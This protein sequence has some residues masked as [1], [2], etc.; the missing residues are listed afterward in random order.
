MAKAFVGHSFTDDDKKL[1][2]SVT[3]FLEAF[4][5][6]NP[7]FV[8]VHAE[9]AR[10]EDIVDK[11]LPMLRS[12]DIFIGI[13]S[14]K[15]R[16]ATSSSFRS[17]LWNKKLQVIEESSLQWKTSD[18]IIQEIA[19]AR[20]R[21]MRLILLLE[22][23]VRAPGGLHGNVEYIQ[24]QRDNMSN[25]YLRLTQ[26]LGAI[27][28]QAPPPQISDVAAPEHS[29]TGEA[30]KSTDESPLSAPKATWEAI[31]YE[32]ALFHAILF[33]DDE[34]LQTV[35]EA[36]SASELSKRENG[37]SRWEARKEY[38]LLIL[39][40]GGSFVN[41]EKMV[42]QH[43]T[44]HAMV[45]M[46]ARAVSH[47]NDDRGAIK[48]HEEAAIAATKA[49]SVGAAARS[50]ATAVELCCK[51]KDEV[52]A[53][54]IMSLLAALPATDTDVRD[55]R[56]RAT[57]LM[58]KFKGHPLLRI[59]ALEYQ[60]A[61]APSDAD[62]RF[63]LAYAYSEAD[64]VPATLLHY[65]AIPDAR[66]NDTAWNNLGVARQSLKLSVLAIEAFN[67]AEQKGNTLSM[68]NL[69]L[70][71]LKAG[72]YSEAEA[73]CKK[74]L[75]GP[76]PHDNLPSTFAQIKGA[77]IDEKKQ[78]ESAIEEAE[79]RSRLMKEL[80]R[81]MLDPLPDLVSTQ[82]MGPEC[83]LTLMRIGDQI[84]LR[85]QYEQQPNALFRAL[86]GLASTDT[87]DLIVKG[88]LY[89][90]AAVGTI[91]RKKKGETTTSTALALGLHGPSDALILFADDA[92]SIGVVENPGKNEKKFKIDVVSNA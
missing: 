58:A 49:G 87:Y 37:F 31:D 80:G 68:S 22:V 27:L 63:A 48:L 43:R 79:P 5:G 32:M 59:A 89:G 4:K 55:A 34:Y 9:G 3:E 25:A 1:V 38:S 19:I 33:E 6:S 44:D 18:W 13:C 14:K 50:L 62:K 70:A 23:G 53:R 17:A 36:F 72:F 76:D 41:L 21:E 67:T 24:F 65:L 29:Q 84:E 12:C 88:T 75:E 73:M 54:R 60:V 47:F 91:E 51:V 85:G 16:V 78:E 11:V 10:P 26:M 56:L 92:R 28:V 77:R 8:W 35:N 83:P 7:A 20:E 42:N 39:D 57:A 71:Y 64:D 30:P 82:W 46:L 45:S 90:R 74:G 66:R 61:L 86:G 52:E 2:L 69:A 40:K 15:E 81:G